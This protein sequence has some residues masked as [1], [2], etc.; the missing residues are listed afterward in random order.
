MDSAETEVG[1]DDWNRF[2]RHAEELINS[3][4]LEERELEYK[5]T[6]GREFAEARKAVLDNDQDWASKLRV[7][8]RSRP[9]HPMTWQSIDNIKK[10]VDSSPEEVFNALKEIWTDAASSTIVDRIRA[11]SR[12]LP[13]RVIH[14][15]GTRIRAISA[16]LMG[17]NVENTRLSLPIHSRERTGTPNTVSPQGM[18]MRPNYTTMPWTFSTDSKKKCEDE[19]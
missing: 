9:G 17:L 19:G 10:W 7:G 3:G 2:V 8:L 4:N 12:H 6:L 5:R 15:T 14:G 13:D 18:L 11:F 16:L 1:G